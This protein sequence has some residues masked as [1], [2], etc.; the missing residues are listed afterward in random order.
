MLWHCATSSNS[1]VTSNEGAVLTM[2]LA[3]VISLNWR[4]ISVCLSKARV[5]KK[6][7]NQKH[8]FK[9]YFTLELGQLLWPLQ[10]H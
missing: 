1:K 8:N 5:G 6:N 7:P 9:Y 3:C 4:F 2:G 10:K